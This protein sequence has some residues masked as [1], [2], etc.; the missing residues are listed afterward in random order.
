MKNDPRGSLWRQWEF[1]FHTPSSFDHARMSTSDEETVET[2]HQ[3]GIG[4]LV[5]TDHHAM[6]VERIARL[7]SLAAN[8]FVVF[9]G[10]ELRSELGG[11]V[12]VHYI[13]IFPEDC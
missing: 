11:S 13:G 7:Q 9:P 10:I 2:L 12:S 3:A 4:A 8:K 5:V 6:D 1:H